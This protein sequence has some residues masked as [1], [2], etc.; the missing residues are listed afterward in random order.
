[1]ALTPSP[2]GYN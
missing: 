2:R 1:M